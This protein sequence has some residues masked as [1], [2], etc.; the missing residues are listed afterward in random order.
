MKKIYSAL[1]LIVFAIFGVSAQNNY[2]YYYKGEK[3]QL[4]VDKNFLNIIVN[5][6]FN[7]SAVTRLGFEEF[8][9]EMDRSGKQTQLLGRLKFKSTPS[10]A[11]FNEKVNALRQIK[12][13]KHVAPYFSRGENAEPIGVSNYFYIKLKNANDLSILQKAAKEQNLQIIKQVPNMPE[14]YILS[15]NPISKKTSVEA[16]NSLYE[17]G[18]FADVDPAFRFD[19]G[20]KCTNDT[21]FG[22]LWGLDN[23]SNPAFDI[24]ACAAWGITEGLGINVAALDQG[25]QKTHGDLAGNIHPLSFDAESGTAPSVYNAS[26]D[27]GTHVGGT[28]AAI[29][30]NNLQVVG[31]A[32]KSRLMSVSHELWLTSTL[33]AELASGISWAWQNNA[34]AINNSW[35]DQGG[36]FYGTMQSAILENAIIN[37]MNM[38]R[39]GKGTLVVFAAGNYGS[40]GPVMD[41]PG[42]FHANI[43]TAG[44]IE[45][46]G[47]RAWFS[48]YG[49][50]LDVVAPGDNILSTVNGNA[51]GPKSGTSMAAPHVTGTIALILSAN[52]CLTGAEVRTILESTAQKI[53]SYTY[54]TTSGRPNGTWNNEMG[55][56]LIDAH[57]A[58]LMAQ[59]MNTVPF[60]LH[61]KDSPADVAAEPNYI[62]PYMWNSQDIWVRV[63]ADNGLVHE[64]P[65]YSASSI[66]NTVYVR[67]RNNSCV[68]STGTEQLKLYWSKAGTS[69]Q[70]PSHWNGSLFPTGQ[71]KGDLIGT[72]TIPVIMP[73]QE[74]IMSFP[75]IVPNPAIYAPINAEPWHF[76]LVTRIEAANDPMTYIETTDLNGNVMN[77]NNI[78]WRNCTVVDT[79]IN[80][81]APV[82]GVVALENITDEPKTYILEFV[83]EETEEGPAIFEEAFVRIHMDEAMMQAWEA[84][85][86][87]TTGMEQQEG[88][89]MMVMEDN[90]SILMHFEPQTLATM[91]L[92]FQFNPDQFSDKTQFL[93]HVVHR[94]AES[95]EIIGGETYII[96]KLKEG[97]QEEPGTCYLKALA[98]NPSSDIVVVYYQLGDS[99]GEAQLMLVGAYGDAEGVEEYFDIDPGST[100]TEINIADYPAGYY[101]I[102]LLCDGEMVS[103]KTL[104]KQ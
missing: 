18:L 88:N 20:R 32:P 35:G 50:M 5:E 51:T 41:Y 8:K 74:A 14:W 53:G 54:S 85:G 38:G 47:S 100:E 24:N 67:V 99:T 95:Y 91:N 97:G 44:A 6:G 102:I 71:V 64:N 101:T 42:N 103:S 60:D 27:H 22:S 17:T 3:V 55:Y 21:D 80:N 56:G 77:N 78:A 34:D 83:K 11:E 2:F 28:M 61:V 90:A 15:V 96:N 75:W 16:S 70:W 66:P 57:A 1:I 25:I 76:C 7:T 19:F 94:D 9:L 104:I 40:S 33:S 23:S 36:A 82:G 98:P 13:I 87:E 52:P 65:D 37:A 43:V 73:G 72:V 62:T 49:T 93:Y 45:V 81:S 31:V 89:I 10:D 12:N 69:L 79:P 26:L 46:G 84:A 30:N 68:A 59:A 39:G 4:T 92:T 58:V 86:G 63:S 48:G 29:K